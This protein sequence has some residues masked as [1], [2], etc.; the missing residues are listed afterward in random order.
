MLLINGY[1]LTSTTKEEIAMIENIACGKMH[2]PEIALWI[3]QH[4]KRRPQKQRGK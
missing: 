1:D 4:S 2:E 3:K